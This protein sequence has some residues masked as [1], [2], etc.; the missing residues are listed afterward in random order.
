[1]HRNPLSPL[2][3]TGFQSQGIMHWLHGYSLSCIRSHLRFNDQK[4]NSHDSK[5][6]KSQQTT[7]DVK[8]RKSDRHHLDI[9]IFFS[10][11]SFKRYHNAR[12]SQALDVINIL[13][14]LYICKWLLTIKYYNIRSALRIIERIFRK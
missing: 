12:N 4:R 13:K 2:E 1:M 3:N 8:R 9:N 6:C 5:I 7:H 11:R 14:F 10:V